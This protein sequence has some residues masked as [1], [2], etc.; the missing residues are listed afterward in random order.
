M[1]FTGYIFPDPP[2]GGGDGLIGCL[3]FPVGILIIISIPVLTFDECTH[4][5]QKE[6]GVSPVVTAQSKDV[7]E[8]RF[9]RADLFFLN[10]QYAKAV[11][12]YQAGIAEGKWISYHRG[13]A[14]MSA[15]ICTEQFEVA[16]NVGRSLIKDLNWKDEHGR[17]IPLLLFASLL[18][19]GKACEANA[20]SEEA[21]LK[22]EVN[23]WPYP[24]MLYLNNE[25]SADLLK[26]KADGSASMIPRLL[27]SLV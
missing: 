23:E 19:Q 11:S 18:A 5:K 15:S 8:A 26:A 12:E 27:H 17:Y 1:R 3:T 24:I 21:V 14:L 16:E 2:S 13:T 7:I 25:T 4:K 9:A 10:R 22:M 6:G 20:I